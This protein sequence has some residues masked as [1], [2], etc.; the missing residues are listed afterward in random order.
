[1]GRNDPGGYENAQNLT[2]S[3]AK[4]NGTI[5]KILKRDF[6]RSVICLKQTSYEED[7]TFLSFN[8]IVE[9]GRQEC[10]MA[11]YRLLTWNICT[12]TWYPYND[13]ASI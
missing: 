7:I 8:K 2:I 4:T 10:H 5:E 9:N 1:V 3:T 13:V 11:L 6:Q 12:M